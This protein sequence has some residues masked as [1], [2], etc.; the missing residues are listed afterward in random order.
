MEPERVIKLRPDIENASTLAVD[1]SGARFFVRLRESIHALMSATNEGYTHWIVN[2]SGGKDSTTTLIVAL[3]TALSCP[4][5]VQRI[6]IVYCDT[7]VEIPPIQQYA[8]NF[9]NHLRHF[10]RTASLPLCCHIVYPST[11]NSFWVCL[12][13]KGYPP[14]HQRFRWCTRRLK[15]EPVERALKGFLKPD[16]SVIV[17]GVRFG[18]SR[19][20]DARL[21]HA[22][23]RGGECGQGLWFEYSARLRAGYLAPIVSW[24]ECDVWDFLNLYAPRLGYPTQHLEETVYNG[25]G[26][27]FGCWMCTVVR[28]DKAMERIMASQQWSHLRP[29]YEFRQRVKEI[30]SHPHSRVKRTDGKPGRLRLS[31]RQQLLE[32]LLALQTRTRT[33]L[34]TTEEI[35]AIRQLWQQERYGGD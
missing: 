21:Y 9:L 31:T 1:E 5:Q 14:P 15:I 29:L 2:Y 13:G 26:T 8:L 23:N 3:E 35:A 11:E 20:R 19:S 25:R 7:Q 17:T 24:G 33:P 4:G 16:T 30:T 27:R 34:I 28:Q 18:E 22:C 32:E 6:D 12:L 10:D